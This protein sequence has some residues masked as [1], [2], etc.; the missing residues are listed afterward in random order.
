MRGGLA[1]KNY[2]TIEDCSAQIT[3]RSSSGGVSSIGGLV[4]INNGHITNSHTTGTIMAL[5]E[6]VML[7]VLSEEELAI[8]MT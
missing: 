6:I 4:G 2:V 8:L 1:G 7:Q 3:I 5:L